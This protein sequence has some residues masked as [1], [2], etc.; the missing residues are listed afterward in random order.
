MSS[1]KFVY[2]SSYIRAGGGMTDEVS[3]FIVKDGG[4]FQPRPVLAQ[5]A[6]Y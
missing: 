5:S 1:K 4:L 6:F 2:L 3:L